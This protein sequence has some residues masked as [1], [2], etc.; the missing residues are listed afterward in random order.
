LE[1]GRRDG[2]GPQENRENGPKKVFEVKEGVWEG[3]V[4]EDADQENLGLCYRSQGDVQTIER[5][6]LSSIK[7]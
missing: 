4:R 3:R 5:K 7:E 1:K 2:G 6:D